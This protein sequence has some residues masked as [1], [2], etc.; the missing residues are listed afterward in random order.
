[1]SPSVV[2]H[3]NFPISVSPSCTSLGDFCTLRVVFF[4]SR[5]WLSVIIGFVP[6]G[7]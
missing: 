3:V 6:Y 1:M 7:M 5:E 2:P 4:I